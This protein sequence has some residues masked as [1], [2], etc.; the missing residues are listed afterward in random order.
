MKPMTI[1]LMPWWLRSCTAR[2][3]AGITLP[4]FGVYLRAAY[5]GNEGVQ[6]HEA[7]H[8]EQYQRLGAWRYY[9]TYG[10]QAIT[11]GYAQHPMEVEAKERS[12]FG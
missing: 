1:K 8:W 12:G 9:W 3:V 2:W 11:H 10:R 5:L 7:I 4:P 6:A